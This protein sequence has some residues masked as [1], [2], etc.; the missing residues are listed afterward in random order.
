MFLMGPAISEATR[1][2]LE[3]AKLLAAHLLETE[4]GDVKFEG[5]QF[6]RTGSN[7]VLSFQEVVRA[8]Y[9]G[10]DT[11]PGFEL[12][13]EETV[14]Y[15]PPDRNFP[16]GMQLAV[17]LVDR[18]TGRVRVRDFCAV[19]DCGRVINPMIVEGQL[20]GGVAQGIGQALLEECT[21][22]PTSG[23]LVAG[24]FMD[25]AMPRA[26]DLPSIRFAHQETLNPNNILGV[27]GSGESGSIAA[28]AAV[29][30]AVVD[31]L[32]QFGVREI[33]MPITSQKVWRAL[34]GAEERHQPA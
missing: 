9:T 12:G 26:D 31:A 7:G 8:A 23:Q 33:P 15:D 28:P 16:S 27:K 32:W 20:H 14:F 5:G 34:H 13:L 10:H 29:A 17:V 19:D 4:P 3:K 6:M 24:S 22:D 25:Y 1:R 11:P 30:N 2:I 18:E 21:Y